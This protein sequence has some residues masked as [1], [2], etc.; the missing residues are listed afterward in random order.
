VVVNGRLPVLA[1]PPPMLASELSDRARA[2]GGRLAVEVS[3]A[4][5]AAADVRRQRQGSQAEQVAR[6]GAELP[7]PQLQLPFCFSAE[8]GPSQLEALTDSMAES[9]ASW[10]PVSS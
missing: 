2:V 4:L 1:L 10:A 6:L 3:E 8:L 5:L 7:L 9:M